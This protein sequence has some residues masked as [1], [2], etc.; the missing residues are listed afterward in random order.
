MIFVKWCMI[1]SIY[2]NDVFLLFFVSL[3]VDVS[4][5]TVHAGRNSSINYYIL[6]TSSVQG[7]LRLTCLKMACKWKKLVGVNVMVHW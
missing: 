5:G 6:P 3:H 2:M 4:L 1:F 7:H